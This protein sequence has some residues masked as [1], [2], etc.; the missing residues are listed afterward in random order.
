MSRRES[1]RA[2]SYLSKAGDTAESQYARG[3]LATLQGDYSA[4]KGYLTT[5]KNAGIQEAGDVLE[6]ISRF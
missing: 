3:V 4:A 6:V 1:E 2:S 5:A